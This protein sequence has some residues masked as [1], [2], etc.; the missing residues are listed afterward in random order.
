MSFFFFNLVATGTCFFTFDAA[1]LSFFFGFAAVVE[2]ISFF[3]FAFFARAFFSFIFLLPD[4]DCMLN[5]PVLGPKSK[6]PE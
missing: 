1:I 3:C 2:S 5:P 4:A 6:D